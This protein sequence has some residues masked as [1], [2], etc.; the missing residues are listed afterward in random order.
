MFAASPICP[1][2]KHLNPL[3]CSWP[4]LGV[5]NFVY[6]TRMFV[7]VNFFLK[8]VL[9]HSLIVATIKVVLS[10]CKELASNNAIWPIPL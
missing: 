2:K 3:L 5:V 8:Q 10:I 7:E 4:F 1:T 6:S 9:I